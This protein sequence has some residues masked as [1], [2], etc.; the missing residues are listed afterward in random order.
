MWYLFYFFLLF[1]QFEND[2][3]STSS[4]YTTSPQHYVYRC[5]V[6][7]NYQFTSSF[8]T[9]ILNDSFAMNGGEIDH[10]REI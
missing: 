3:N 9:S 4:V 5:S 8:G 1:Q 7:D 10:M 6:I 2:C